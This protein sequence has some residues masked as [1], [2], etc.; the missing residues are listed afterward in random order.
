MFFGAQP[1]LVGVNE[2]QVRVEHM[3]FGAQPGLDGVKSGLSTCF[4]EA[5]PGLRMCESHPKRIS[6]AQPGLGKSGL[7]LFT[8]IILCA[9]STRTC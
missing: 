4:F 2:T 1:G 9:C 8:N 7:S 3:V 5:Q 6:F